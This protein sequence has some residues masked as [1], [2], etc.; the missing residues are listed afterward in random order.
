MH[1]NKVTLRLAQL[2]LRWVDVCGFADSGQLS[3]LAS[4]GC[5]RS[6]G[7]EGNHRCALNWPCISDC[8]IST[9]PDVF[10]YSG[11]IQIIHLVTSL[12]IYFPMN[13]LI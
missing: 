9:G 13:R 1:I 8:V 10:V 5:E 2:I 4:S 11:A 7:W 6:T 3:L 12:L